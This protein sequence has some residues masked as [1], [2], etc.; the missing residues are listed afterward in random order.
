M[1]NRLI[2]LSR[3][4][5]LL[6]VSGLLGISTIAAGKIFSADLSHFKMEPKILGRTGLKVNPLGFGASRTLQPAV[7]KAALN[8]GLNFIDTGRTYFN[9]QNEEMLGKTLK[10]IRDQVIIQSKIPIRDESI[11]NNLKNPETKDKI[12]T[13]LENTLNECLQALQTDYIDIMLLHN[14]ESPELLFNEE[15]MRFFEDAKTSGKIRAHGF[16]AH[17]V[18]LKCV[19]AATKNMFYD[20]LMVPYNFKGSYNHSVSGYFNEWDQ[21]A[22]EG[23]LKKLH[24]NNIGTIAMKTCSAGALALDPS[25]EPS[26]R[27]AIKWVIQKD[28]I[29]LASVAMRN[30]EEIEHNSSMFTN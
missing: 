20:V 10:G 17:S 15:V 14:A 29:C 27:D 23:Y 2:K 1:R 25:S 4:E 6:K 13:I 22:L 3:K 12:R 26:I 8:K 24:D 19:E 30:F 16:S 11:L 7:V 18:D 5:F 9:G 21:T 28:F